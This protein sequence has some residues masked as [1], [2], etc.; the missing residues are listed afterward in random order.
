MTELTG[1]YGGYFG[2]LY[3]TSFIGPPTPEYKVMFE[4]AAE[5]YHQLM[6]AIK[7]GVCGKDLAP[8]LA[9]KRRRQATSRFPSLRAG[10]RLTP[11]RSCFSRRVEA[12]DWEFELKAG[13]CLNVAGWV[14][15]QDERM[16]V[17]VGD[18]V[19]VTESGVRSFHRSP[20]IGSPTTYSPADPT[21]SNPGGFQVQG[22]QAGIFAL[23][24]LETWRLTAKTRKKF[25]TR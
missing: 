7:P 16:G 15:D 12:A 17:W 23:Q 6:A 24:S 5:S 11:V 14:V 19:T 20:S 18:T 22:P 13:Y 8:A 25:S 2:K 10:A 9:G 1:G 21:S 4:L 3:T